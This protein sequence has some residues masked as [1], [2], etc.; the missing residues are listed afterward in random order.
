MLVYPRIADIVK[1]REGKIKV[2]PLI[3]IIFKY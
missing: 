1:F 2:N 3:K